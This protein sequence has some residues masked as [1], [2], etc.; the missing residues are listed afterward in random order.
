MQKGLLND[1]A[2]NVVRRPQLADESSRFR[3]RYALSTLVLTPKNEWKSV[4][5]VLAYFDTTQ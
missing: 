5:V 4:R 1:L 3:T 2:G